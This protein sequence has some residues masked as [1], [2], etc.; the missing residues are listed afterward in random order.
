MKRIVLIISILLVGARTPVV[1]AQQG[2]DECLLRYLECT[3]N[4]NITE[5]LQE[6]LD[7]RNVQ[8]PATPSTLPEPVEGPMEI[9]GSPIPNQLPPVPGSSFPSWEELL[10]C[11]PKDDGIRLPGSPPLT[12]VGFPGDSCYKGGG[13]KGCP[14]LLPRGCELVLGGGVVMPDGGEAAGFF[15]FGMFQISY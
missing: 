8:V 6:L 7:C 12:P 4:G 10:V 2:D 9:P 11:C 13:L 1:S 15:C 5:C 3:V 14:P